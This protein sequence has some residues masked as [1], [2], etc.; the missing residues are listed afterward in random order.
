MRNEIEYS[1][2][3]AGVAANYDWPVRFDDHDGF[4]G[5]TQF[6]EDGETANNRILLS[7]G[8]AA[9][10]ISFYRKWHP[11]KRHRAASRG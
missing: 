5:V 6:D 8:Q 11:A 2:K 4:L 1:E 3:I 10:L 7:P 9:A